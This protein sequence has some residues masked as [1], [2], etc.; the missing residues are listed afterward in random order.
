MEPFRDRKEGCSLFWGGD[1]ESANE[2][3][4]GRFEVA[5]ADSW[6]TPRKEESGTVPVSHKEAMVS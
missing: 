5:K 4:D 3:V 1:G 6:R 2:E